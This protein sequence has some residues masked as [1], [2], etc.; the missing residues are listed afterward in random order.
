MSYDDSKAIY[1]EPSLPGYWRDTWG[2]EY[3]KEG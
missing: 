3:E 2:V 1:R